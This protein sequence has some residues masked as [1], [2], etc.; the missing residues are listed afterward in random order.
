MIDDTVYEP[1]KQFETEYKDKVNEEAIN[2][3]ERLL[4]ESKVNIEEN[5]LSVKKYNET[6]EKNNNVKKKLNR[7]KIYRTVLYALSVFS[8]IVAIILFVK[9]FTPVNISIGVILILLG[10]GAIIYNIKR[11]NQIIKHT[12]E[13]LNAL[14]QQVKTL[15][16]EC[17]NQV[18]P[19]INLFD[20]NM[21]S[22]IIERAVPMIKL[23]DYF[24]NERLE[25][26]ISNFGYKIRNFKNESTILVQSGTLN[27]NPFIF[28]KNRVQDMVDKPF[29]GTRIIT[30]TETETDSDGKTRT[31]TRSQTL[32]A[33]I[34]K[35]V[36]RYQ[37][38]TYL[39]YGNESGSNLSFTRTPTRLFNP[40]EKEVDKY[41]HKCEK[42][43]EDIAEEAVKKGKSFTPIANTNFECLF[44]ALD[45]NHEVEFRLLFTPLAQNNMIDLVTKNKYYGDDFV[46][47]KEG[48]INYIRT[49]H[50]Q[51]FDLSQS[52]GIFLSHDQKV[53]RERF[54][55]YIN[56]YFKNVYFDLAP[57]LAI[58]LY[59]QHSITGGIYDTSLMSNYTLYEQEVMANKLSNNIF[60][61]DGARTESILKVVSSE[62]VG[63]ADIVTIRAHAF[64][65]IDQVEYVS[66]FGG[67]GRS[68]AVPVHYDD[69][70][71][72][73]KDEN[74]V[75]DKF[76]TNRQ[77]AES[78][79]DDISE[80]LAKNN[81]L[82]D[83]VYKNGLICFATDSFNKNDDEALEKILNR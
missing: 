5:E 15:Y 22:K 67:D 68:H 12:S 57:L 59:Q 1:L 72:V 28:V 4:K 74:I 23:D 73:T 35:P 29:I 32:T 8:F 76:V 9:G 60:R 48:P 41:V 53:I 31:V 44:G 39:V 26:L 71:E 19:L 62:K 69:Y 49:D 47:S 3:Y 70:F 78:K 30:W 18:R 14:D 81:N 65:S 10:I 66:V 43:L 82:R 45:R 79:A 56:D 83:I 34:Y 50:I 51:G 11:I 80:Y 52:I 33:T 13:I 55:N 54:I 42:K 16:V 64:N 17:L 36:P 61:P 7:Y 40:S 20:F 58:P 38:L 75:L 63:N 37:D 6:L 21:A 46:F 77:V 27:S 2:T 24:K 25:S